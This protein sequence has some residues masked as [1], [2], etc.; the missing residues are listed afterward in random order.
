MIS[1]KVIP[2][3][4]EDLSTKPIHA[5]EAANVSHSKHSEEIVAHA[6]ERGFDVRLDRPRLI[7]LETRH[8]LRTVPTDENPGSGAN[9]RR[10]RLGIEITRSF[11]SPRTSSRSKDPRAERVTSKHCTRYAHADHRQRRSTRS[12][13]L[14]RQG[15]LKRPSWPGSEPGLATELPAFVLARTPFTHA[16]QA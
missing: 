6:C 4:R 13:R 9:R 15:I 8:S 16:S 11:K 7:S 1:T 3:I 12:P 5:L 2:E 10:D 14:P